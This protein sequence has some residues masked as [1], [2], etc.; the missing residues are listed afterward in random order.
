MKTALYIEDG[1]T[2]LVLTPENGF[3]KILF[4]RYL[5]KKCEITRGSFYECR[6]GHVR[7]MP[8]PSGDDSLILRFIG[9]AAETPDADSLGKALILAL[10][11]GRHIFN[12]SW[13]MR[14]GL[15][16]LTDAGIEIPD[17]LREFMPH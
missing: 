10:T 11:E 1:V 14:D 8:H 12:G 13:V 16:A 4:E 2:Q 6:A 9:T 15:K 7:Y 17:V 5:G 3:E